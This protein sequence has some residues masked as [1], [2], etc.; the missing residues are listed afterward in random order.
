LFSFTK[1]VGIVII[2]E[3]KKPMRRLLNFLLSRV[4]LI[5]L[6]ILLQLVMVLVL[7]VWVSSYAFRYY[8]L[9]LILSSILVIYLI[10]KRGNPTYSQAWIIVLLVFPLFGGVI[11][12]LFGNKRVPKALMRQAH[13]FDDEETPVLTQ[14]ESI[15]A[16]LKEKDATVAKQFHYVSRYPGYPVYQHTRVEYFPSG[17]EMFAVL[18][19]K[20]K[21]AKRYIFLEFFIIWEGVMWEQILEILLAKVKEGVDVRLIY[22][23]AG[24][25][26]TLPDGY[27][28]RLRRLGIHC[29]IFNKVRARLMVQMNNRDHRKICVI[30]GQTGFLGGMNVGDEYI[31]VID[32]FGHWKDAAVMLEGEAVDSLTVMFLQFYSFLIGKREI[33]E[34][35]LQDPFHFANIHHEGY[36]QPY[37]DTPTDNE[38][39]GE[40]MHLNM[41]N[42][43]KHYIYI[44]TPYLVPSYDMVKALTIAAKDGVDVRIMV[45]HIPDKWYVHEVTRSHYQDLTQAGI[46]IF[47]YLPGFLHSKIFVCDNQLAICGSTNMDYRSYYLNYECGVMF[48]DDPAILKIRD[49]FLKTQTECL[50]ITLASCKKT[51]IVRRVARAVLGLLSPLL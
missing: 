36:V 35:Y 16:A 4:V 11:Y 46:R 15:L 25:I 28:E 49:D 6:L 18:L 14:Q 44:M 10:Q 21:S 40:T 2:G 45:P 27:D 31:N 8:L 5:S 42:Q 43:A 47:E 22:D 34:D 19:D 24:C 33:Y 17:E 50:E 32:R 48:Y 26:S 12:L 38:D 9:L 1:T 3:T 23:D 30:D 20:L 37:S 39:V 13:Q 51:G 29:Y 41:I 7:V